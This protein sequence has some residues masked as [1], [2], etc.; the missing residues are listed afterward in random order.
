MFGIPDFSIALVYFLCIAAAG[1][2][3]VY[4]VVNWNKG[5]DK[6]EAIEEDLKW[7]EQEQEIEKTL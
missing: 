2:C 1:A 7:E 3:V 5:G 4:G 6:D